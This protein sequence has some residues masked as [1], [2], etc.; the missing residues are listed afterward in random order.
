MVK[1]MAR[2]ICF[3]FLRS[4]EVP[5]TKV[6]NGALTPGGKSV[7]VGRG[8]FDVMCVFM[9]QR[10]GGRLRCGSLAANVAVHSEVR[11]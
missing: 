4:Q 10:D 3:T 8:G 9:I 1:S 2:L 5:V 11:I 6:G 7:T